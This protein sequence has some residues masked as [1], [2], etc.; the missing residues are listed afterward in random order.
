MFMAVL[1][2]GENTI[3]SIEY[4]SIALTVHKHCTLKAYNFSLEKNSRC[5][6][7]AKVSE[8]RG[9]EEDSWTPKVLR[10][11]STFIKIQERQQQITNK[12]TIGNKQAKNVKCKNK[13]RSAQS[14]FFCVC[15]RFI[16]VTSNSKENSLGVW[17]PELE[18]KLFCMLHCL[19]V[20]FIIYIKKVGHPF[21]N[22]NNTIQQR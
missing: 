20:F 12:Q 18:D 13:G 16:L 10:T 8:V 3:M 21:K 19:F 14:L 7:C 2:F 9:K 4:V 15:F 6:F 1:Y 11:E 5:I 17:I 22:N